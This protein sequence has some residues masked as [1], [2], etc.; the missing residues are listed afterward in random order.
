MPVLHLI[1][2]PKGAGKF[3]LYRA[4]IAP[5]CPGLLFVNTDE[6]RDVL[7]TQGKDF[8]TKM[9]F[10]QPSGL[11][12]LARARAQGFATVLYVVCVDEPWRLRYR[13]PQRVAEGGKNPNPHEIITHYL[14]TLS[15]L[16]EAVEFAD[17]SL[18]FDGSEMEQGG[19]VLVASIAAGRMHL[20]TAL[21]PRWAD[22]VLGFSER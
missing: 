22:K 1:A 16:R 21:R 15:L 10:T 14:Q 12:L 3:T 18:L 13:V 2:G 7:L 6:S 4:L 20:H 5:R 17:L 9:L 11:E 8:A 19:P